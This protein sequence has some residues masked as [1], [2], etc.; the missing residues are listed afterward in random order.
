MFK[1]VI[2][3]AVYLI[4]SV[5]SE[6]KYE[7][8]SPGNTKILNC[9]AKSNSIYWIGPAFNETSGYPMNVSDIYGDIKE[10]RID[11]YGSNNKTNPNL[12]HRNRIKIEKSDGTFNLVIKNASKNDAGLY[13]CEDGLNVTTRK[14]TLLQMISEQFTYK[15]FFLFIGKQGN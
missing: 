6:V 15:F 14:L 11:T 3:T 12:D 9:K 1:V 7:Y 8:F 10:W 5:M 13:V 2:F 4:V